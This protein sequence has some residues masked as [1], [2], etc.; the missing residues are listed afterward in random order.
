MV[1]SETPRPPGE[2]A[3][4][5][6][7]FLAGRTAAVVV[8]G[9]EHIVRMWSPTARVLLGR[10]PEQVLGRPLDALLASGPLPFPPPGE[11]AA[12]FECAPGLRHADGSTFPAVGQA[13]PLAAGPADAA[14]DG[15]VWL[16]LFADRREGRDWQQD[17]ALIRALFSQDTV[18]LSFTDDALRPIRSNTGAALR[19]GADGSLPY[20]LFPEEDA[21]TAHGLMRRAQQSGA[22]V[23]GI[24]HP[25][26]PRFSTVHDQ[27]FSLVAMPLTDHNGASL[28]T[29]TAFVNVTARHRTRRRFAVL[30]EASEVIGSSLDVTRTAQHVADSL[31]PAFCREA[32][33]DLVDGILQGEEPPPGPAVDLSALRRLAVARYRGGWHEELLGPGARLPGLPELPPDSVLRGLAEG[34]TVLVP[35]VDRMRA[36]LGEEHRRLVPPESV[37]AIVAPL[38][39][40]GLILGYV[41]VW[42]THRAPPFDPDD[43]ELVGEVAS[44][45]ALGLDNARRYTR[46]HGVAVALQHSLLPPAVSD[47]TAAH[48]VG[49]YAPADTAA[50]VGGDWY[51]VIPLSSL[52]VA[53]V[54]GDVFG[55]GLHASATMGRLRTAVQ[56]LSELDLEPGELLARLD[57]L[58]VRLAAETRPEPGPEGGAAGELGGT[59]LYAVYDPVS[60]RLVAAS[61]GHPAPL[62]A[63]PDG[64]VREFP[65]VP[66][67]PLGVGGMPFEPLEVEVASGSLLA[68][69]TDGLLDGWGGGTQGPEALAGLLATGQREST[70]LAPLA[71]DVLAAMLPVSRTDDAALLLVRPARLTR[72]AI[73]SWELPAEGSMVA[74]ARRLAS[75]RLTEWGLEELAFTTELIVSELVTNAARYAG[76]PVGLRLIRDSVLVCEVSD[77]SNSQPR[78]TRAR[79][80]DEGGRG[81]FLVAQMADRWGCRYGRSGKT[82]WTE[83]AIPSASADPD[84]APPGTPATPGPGGASEAPSPPPGGPAPTGA[85]PGAGGAP[86]ADGAAGDPALSGTPVTLSG[87]TPAKARPGDADGGE[88]EDGLTAAPED[89]GPRNAAPEDPGPRNAAPAAAPGPAASRAPVTLS[90]PGPAPAGGADGAE[91]T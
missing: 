4:E 91:P 55:H 24:E 14:T 50:G 31:V 40:R 1:E 27:A 44:R 62:V 47:T 7:A 89:A 54:I 15:T 88:A 26:R 63:G 10:P 56:T 3:A 84:P 78:L 48:S 8:A 38:I 49:S 21:R 68:F 46:E 12:P 85:T 67:P 59:L 41:S 58:V 22:P 82:I 51:D 90:G 30:Q 13:V 16:L 11:P 6:M 75:A 35:D 28:G 43:V 17:R 80:L 83:Q 81:L 71:R 20:L 79:Q 86:V 25:V 32:T 74:E 37:R 34:H 39:A 72:D 64:A 45:A 61:A 66:G 2:G 70:P 36:E 77:P 57:D 23:V 76:G 87:R 33:V 18:G 5:G 42:R 29:A 60:Q 65:V 19:P 69:Y 9:G 52:R 53:F 73:A